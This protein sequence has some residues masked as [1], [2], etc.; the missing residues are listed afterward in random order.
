MALARYVIGVLLT[1]TGLFFGLGA[2]SYVAQPDPEIATWGVVVMIVVFG[3]LP[4]LVAFALLRPSLIRAA[5][6]CPQCGSAVYQLADILRRYIRWWVVFVP[7][8]PL[9]SLWSL[10]RERQVRC[11]Q[12]EWLYL[13]PSMGTRTFRVLFWAFALI[14]LFVLV[15]SLFF[16]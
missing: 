13:S 5:K 3:F 6:P 4:L 12:C 15:G 10:S 1:A 14:A 2:L 16:L 9:I 7:G 8:W 11:G